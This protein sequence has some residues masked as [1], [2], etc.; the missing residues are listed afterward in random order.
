MT[1]VQALELVAVDA[2]RPPPP[3]G[4]LPPSK[5]RAPQLQLLAVGELERQDGVVLD[6]H[7][8]RSSRHESE[9]VRS[10]SVSVRSHVDRDL[11]RMGAAAEDDALERRDVGVVAPPRRRDVLVG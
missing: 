11:Q 6:V 9:A 2:R 4:P 10:S 8:A 7:R 1:D 3:S 5:H